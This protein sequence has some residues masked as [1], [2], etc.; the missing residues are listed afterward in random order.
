MIDTVLLRQHTGQA[1]SRFRTGVSLYR[2]T[3]EELYNDDYHRD[4]SFG[5]SELTVY[6]WVYWTFIG[7]VSFGLIVS[8]FVVLPS[9][10]VVSEAR[11]LQLM[12][13]VSGFLYLFAHFVFDLAFYAVPMAAIFLGYSAI[14]DLPSDTRASLLVI[15]LAFAPLGIFFAYLTTEHSS[16]GSTAYAIMLGLFAVA[17][18]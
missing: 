14:L 11:E 6:T 7:S 10:E 8:S 12:T 18:K 2:L 16:D 1:R 5:L 3:D 13:G 17:G 15:A 9:L 4:P